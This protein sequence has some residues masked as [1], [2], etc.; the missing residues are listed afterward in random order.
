MRLYARPLPKSLRLIRDAR[1]LEHFC[2]RYSFAE[3]GRMGFWCEVYAHPYCCPAQVCVNRPEGK[4]WFNGP[5]MWEQAWAEVVRCT[6]RG[7]G[8]LYV[9]LATALQWLWQAS[10]LWYPAQWARFRAARR[11]RR[12]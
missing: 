1:A 6:S 3:F 7:H 10:W 8:R 2:Y 11:R 4:T 9:A 12:T 5:D